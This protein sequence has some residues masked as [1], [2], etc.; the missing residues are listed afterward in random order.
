MRNDGDRMKI[1][2]RTSPRIVS[3][4]RQ[5]TDTIRDMIMRGEYRP[6]QTLNQGQIAEQ[7]GV[8]ISPVREA[9]IKLSHE[10]FV[11]AQ[12]NRS[13]RVVTPTAEDLE[14]VYQVFSF[15]A[16]ELAARAAARSGPELIEAL[17]AVHTASLGL[18]AAD[19]DAVEHEF[20]R[21]LHQDAQAP[22]LLMFMAQSLR[23]MPE[24]IFAFN[25]GWR[26]QAIT[27]HEALI[28]AIRDH[29]V[30]AAR[31]IAVRHSHDAGA[32]VVAYFREHGGLT[33]TG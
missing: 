18:P 6:G 25:P 2:S 1:G 22:K 26:D 17:T 24:S 33:G 5:V 4:A 11:S 16:G 21:P 20:H 15:L 29:D 14:D 7:L 19:F 3:L 8:S 27:E 13:F 12:A 30:D 28:G 32:G 10:G 31:R 9:L 23:Y